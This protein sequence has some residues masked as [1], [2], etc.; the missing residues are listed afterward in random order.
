MTPLAGVVAIGVTLSHILGATTIR[1]DPSF[2]EESRPPWACIS[3][4]AFA[5]AHM[6]AFCGESSSILR[7]TM[8]TPVARAPQDSI[9]VLKARNSAAAFGSN[10]GFGNATDHPA[11]V[12]VIAIS[13]EKDLQ[14]EASTNKNSTM[15]H[16]G[17]SAISFWKM[18]SFKHRGDFSF[19]NSAVASAA[20]SFASAADL[21][22]SAKIFSASSTRLFDLRLNSVWIRESFLLKMTSPTMPKAIAPSIT[23]VSILSQSE[24]YGNG[25]IA[26]KT[27]AN[28]AAATN[29]AQPHSQR[30]H[31]DEAPSSWASV[32]FIVPF[33]KRHAGKEFR[34]FWVGAV[35]GALMFMVLYALGAL[36]L[37]R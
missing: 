20:R 32:A 18:A 25:Q 36:S 15:G 34:G 27:S 37:Y 11:C 35:I 8:L 28:T 24:A 2:M 29:P 26:R 13:M 16:F 17:L 33:G 22:A 14:S 10:S 21:T 12:R 9:G 3:E 1:S 19:C 5:S 6:R 23:D 7:A 30:S 31:D 4:P